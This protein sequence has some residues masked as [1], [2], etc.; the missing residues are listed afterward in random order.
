MGRSLHRYNSGKLVYSQLSKCM[1]YLKQP[2][3]FLQLLI[4]IYLQML[5]K[6]CSW[7]RVWMFMVALFIITTTTNPESIL[8]VCQKKNGK[9]QFICQW[10]YQAILKRM[11]RSSLGVQWVKYPGIITAA[12]WV[13]AVAWVLSQSRNFHMLEAC[14]KLNEEELCLLICGTGYIV[15]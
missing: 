3:H 2:F 4:Q 9:F 8:K 6:M 5:A 11:R 1:F 7:G 13:I 12:T 15:K 14:Q 10:K